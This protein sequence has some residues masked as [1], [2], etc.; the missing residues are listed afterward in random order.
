MGSSVTPVTANKHM[1]HFEDSA[2]GP[3]CPFPT[4]WWKRYVDDVI[5]IVKRD[6]VDILFNHI[7]QTDAH[8]KFTIEFLD[9][10]GSIPFLD[11]KC[12]PNNTIHTTVYRKPI[13]TDRY[14]DWNS[15][16]PRSDKRFVIQ[17]LT[18]MAKLFVPL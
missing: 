17:E 16:H 2:L 1:E 12:P 8:I 3:L 14:L 4:P 5:C 9:S 11:T 15:N 6:Q 18:H 10:E 7:N 13:H